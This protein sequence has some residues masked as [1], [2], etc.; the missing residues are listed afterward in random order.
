MS[1]S[2][3]LPGRHQIHDSSIKEFSTAC[4]NRVGLVRLDLFHLST[5]TCCGSFPK[6]CG[7]WSPQLVVPGAV[8]G[9]LLCV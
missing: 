8:D 3:Y 9:T 5:W 1:C 7:A 4:K 6:L 2:R